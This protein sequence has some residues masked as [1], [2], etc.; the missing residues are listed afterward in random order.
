VGIACSAPEARVR[1]TL[2]TLGLTPTF[3][4]IVTAD[5][6][7]RGRPDPEAYLLAAQQ[8]GR[9]PVRCVVVGEFPCSTGWVHMLCMHSEHAGHHDCASNIFQ[10]QAQGDTGWHGLL[11]NVQESQ[12]LGH[13]SPAS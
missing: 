9:P 1:D 13:R 3:G 7:Y 11:R 12:D 5:D 6:V 4:A 10:V 8:L 2:D